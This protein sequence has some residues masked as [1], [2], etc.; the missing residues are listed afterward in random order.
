MPQLYWVD[1]PPY[2]SASDAAV[3]TPLPVILLPEMVAQI[4]AD[5]DVPSLVVMSPELRHIHRSIC[6]KLS[7]SLR[8]GIPIGVHGDGAPHQKRST[9]DVLSWN[10]LTEGFDTRL[11]F[12]LVEKD[13]CC[14]FG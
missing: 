8:E 6:S 1:A 2:C 4:V 9:V 11:L 7:I 12:A 5:V 14:K 13:Y 3:K 10:F